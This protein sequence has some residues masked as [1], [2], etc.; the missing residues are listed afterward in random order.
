VNLDHYKALL[1]AKERELIARRG[2]S[3][4]EEQAAGDGAAGDVGDDSVKDEQK[5]LVFAEDEADASAL[6]DVR[7]ALQRVAD[8]TYGRCAVDD[9]PIEE[10]RLEALPWAKYCTKHQAEIEAGQSIRTPSL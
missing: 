1:I 5:A 6:D 8:G 9:Q 7:L 4:T 2:R 3:G 10:K